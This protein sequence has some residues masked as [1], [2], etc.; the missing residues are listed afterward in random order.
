M[1]PRKALIAATSVAALATLVACGSNGSSGA[2]SSG[3]VNKG[4]TVVW[5]TTDSFKSL[6][7]AYD[8]DNLG[9]QVIYNV[10]QN[11]LK[12]P[13]GGTTPVSDAASSCGFT[14]DTA[15]TCTLKPN[16]QFSNGD[17]LDAAAVVSSLQ[18]MVKINDPNGPAV[19]LGAMK[20]VEAQGDKVVFTLNQH[21]NTFPYV[22]T[23]L[24]S[25]I[26]DPKVYPAHARLADDKIVGSGPYKVES[27]QPSQ[28]LVLAKNAN[29][30]G[31]DDLQN[32]RFIVKYEQS[33]STLKL[34]VEQGNVDIAFTSLTPT[35][36]TDLQDHGSARGVKVLQGAGAA[37]RYIVF[38]T[39]KGPGKDKAV[40]QAVSYLIDRNSIAKNVYND[41]VVP[42][43]SMVA[44][45]LDGATDAYKT[46]Y[47][48]AP[49]KAKAQ[50]VLQAAGIT[51]PVKI[52]AWYTPSHY[53][54]VSADEWTEIR[55]Q[56]NGS[57]LFNITLKSQEWSQY[58]DS[59]VAGAFQMF[60]LGWFPDYTDA[61]DYLSPFY[62]K[63]GFFNNHYDNPQ[64]DAL[65]TKE[66]AEANKDTRKQEIEQAQAIA[67][68]DAPTVPLWQSKQ[69]A[70]VRSNVVG[71]EKTLDR[72]YAIRFWVVGKS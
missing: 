68:Q 40:R 46:Q 53:G 51:T 64:V 66:K 29:Y 33:S 44:Q 25:A 21:D 67:A 71:F 65:I 19:L 69:F 8:Y 60:Q 11:L 52:T 9:Q 47:G 43:Y 59:Y 45:G 62:P 34:D 6:D 38:L 41:Q 15:Y 39:N 56:L 48:A 30:K 17:P 28:Q 49:N 20:K 1:A 58:Q 27:Y 26:V 54:P 36:V 14:G 23:T 57:G 72:A 5:G 31:D 70:A 10:Y 18:R 4:A 22:L 63:G 42:L 61:D 35:D 7:P 12:I 2:G 37:I 50:Q 55:R 32:S 24:A 16:L 13:P 3:T